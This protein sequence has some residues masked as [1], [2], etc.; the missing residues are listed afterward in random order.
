MASLY[1]VVSFDKNKYPYLWQFL[2]NGMKIVMQSDKREKGISGQTG[3][4]VGCPFL[5]KHPGHLVL[6]G[7]ISVS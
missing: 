4:L 2:N 3:A 5:P 6:K 7:R 1:G